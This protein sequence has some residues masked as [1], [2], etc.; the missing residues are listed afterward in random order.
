MASAF[1]LTVCGWAETSSWSEALA[2][3]CDQIVIDLAGLQEIPRDDDLISAGELQ[4]VEQLQD[5]QGDDDE[6]EK[7]PNQRVIG[8]VSIELHLYPIKI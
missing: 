4:Q 3:S 8:R 6:C 5:G 1:E 2:C 7:D